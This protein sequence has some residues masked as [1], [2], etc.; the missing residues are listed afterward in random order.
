MKI[1]TSAPSTLKPRLIAI[2]TKGL[3]RLTLSHASTNDTKAKNPKSSSAQT[4]TDIG[5]Q[6]LKLR[7][8]WSGVT[9]TI[10]C[11]NLSQ[12]APRSTVSRIGQIA[13]AG[14]ATRKLI[15][16]AASSR[17]SPDRRSNVPTRYAP[18]AIPAKKK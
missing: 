9:L 13:V 11:Q 5:D 2:G 17:E 7:L 8:V 10:M 1:P 12:P 6:Y 3:P 18:P 4:P 16:A 14:P 15:L